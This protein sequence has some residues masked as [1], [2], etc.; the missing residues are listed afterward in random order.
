MFGA[1]LFALVVVVVARLQSSS[2][3]AFLLLYS[4]IVVLDAS[5]SL[6]LED[7]LSSHSYYAYPLYCGLIAGL[8]LA[9]I[10]VEN[11]GE[12][13]NSV[14]SDLP[15][16]VGRNIQT[17]MTIALF[18]L[19]VMNGMAVRDMAAKYRDVFSP[20]Q[21][22]IIQKIVDWVE[23]SDKE[24]RRYFGIHESC[25]GN[26]QLPWFKEDLLR[27]GHFLDGSLNLLDALFPQHSYRLNQH[28]DGVEMKTIICYE[29]RIQASSQ[30]M[31]HGPEGLLHSRAPGWHSAISP[32][33]P[34]QLELD[35][36][37]FRVFQDVSFLAQAGE[38]KRAPKLV[39]IESINQHGDW[40]TL[41]KTQLNCEND[42]EVWQTVSLPQMVR[43]RLMRITIYSNCGDTQLL[44]LR[45]LAFE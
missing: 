15:T 35:F 27:S 23:I 37:F 32:D 13:K 19:V 25:K 43:L 7:V 38:P 22:E 39:A 21:L 30:H 1:G 28:L 10:Y 26:V 6:S 8:A 36:G 33:F 24:G 40:V 16:T 34:Q 31:Q 20:P 5:L 42:S 29:K 17:M 14:L 4:F 3:I 18:G 9:L 11:T 2:L 44:T 12:C 45:G 41:T